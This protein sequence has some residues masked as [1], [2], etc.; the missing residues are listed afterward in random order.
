[1]T[2]VKKAVFPVGGLGT[3]FL[4]ATKAMPKEMLPIVD[5]PLIQYAFEEAIEAGIEEFIFVTGRNKD[6]INNHFDQAFEL[7]S[8]LSDKDKRDALKLTSDWMPEPG[9]IAFIRQQ[10]PLG[11]G[12]AVWCARNFIGDEPFAVL[13]ADELM[14]GKPNCLKQMTDFYD[15]HNGSIIGVGEIDIQNSTSYGIIIPDAEISKNATKISG[16]VEKPQPQDAPSN[17]AIVG[18]YILQPDIFSYL[19]KGE[20]GAGGEIQLTDAMAKMLDKSPYYALNFDG[21]RFDCGNKLGC[22]EANIALALEHPE[23]GEKAAG[24]I[25]KY[26]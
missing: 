23:I 9:N 18:R 2:K 26:C 8:I 3:R 7:E 1:M 17:L 13:L 21:R 25:K 20:K 14:V 5:K 22:L 24:I 11:L 4:P 16:M 12:H 10:K 6:T 19:E 15:E